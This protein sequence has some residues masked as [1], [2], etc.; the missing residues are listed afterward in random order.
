M[1]TVLAQVENQSGVVSEL[2]SFSESTKDIMEE[3]TRVNESSK[4]SVMD[5]VLQT[6][7]TVSSMH[8]ID[9]ILRSIQDI[10]TQTNLLSLNASIEAARAGESG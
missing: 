6:E 1:N 8:E 4:T 10:A 5:M 3:L 2:K 7:S 9:K